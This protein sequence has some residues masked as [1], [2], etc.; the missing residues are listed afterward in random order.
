MVCCQLCPQPCHCHH[1]GVGIHCHHFR[2]ATCTTLQPWRVSRSTGPDRFAHSHHALA[3]H[4]ARR[5]CHRQCHLKC[6]TEFPPAR[7][8]HRA[9]Q[10]RSDHRTY[11][12]CPA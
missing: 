6:A 12:R 10:R 9:V 1:D 7:H 8:W 3:V 2:Q 11:P 5:Q 4:S